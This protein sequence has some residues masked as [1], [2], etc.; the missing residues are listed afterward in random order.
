MYILHKHTFYILYV[1]K[2]KVRHGDLLFHD[3]YVCKIHSMKT[4]MA[5]GFV[6]R[7]QKQH[8]MPTSSQEKAK[9]APLKDFVK[10]WQVSNL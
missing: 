3:I 5:L 7:T 8:S 4:G 9:S 2:V 1:H 10:I 6:K